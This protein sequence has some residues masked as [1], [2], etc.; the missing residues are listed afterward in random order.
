LWNTVSTSV[1]DFV[2]DVREHGYGDNTAILVFSEFGRRIKDNGSGTDHG[3]GGVAFLI[4]DSVKGGLYGDYP[5]LDEK[6]QLNGDLQAN[7]DFRSVYTNILED[8][9]GV[10]AAPI[11]NGTFEKFDIFEK[12]T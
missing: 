5:S 3:S 7:N 8:W 6:D 4:G 11:V 10:D 9:I 12:T 1:G 2:D